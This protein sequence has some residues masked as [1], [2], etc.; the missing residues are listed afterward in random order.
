VRRHGPELQR[1]GGGGVEGH[2]ESWRRRHERSSNGT[3][4]D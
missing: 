4:L 3:R 2:L 1:L